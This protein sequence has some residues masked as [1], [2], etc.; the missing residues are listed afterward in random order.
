MKFVRILG[1]VL[2]L[3]LMAWGQGSV[4]SGQTFNR[5]GQPISGA[6][7]AITTTNPCSPTTLCS[8]GAAGGAYTGAT[9][10]AN[11]ASLATDPTLGTPGPNPLVTDSYGNW[12]AYASPGLY[13]S[14][15]YS[16]SITPYVVAVA[17]PFVVSA[18]SFVD[19]IS[20]QSAGGNKTWTG[21][22]IFS[23]TTT[24]NAAASFTS[25][26]SFTGSNTYTT[27]SNTWTV[28]GGNPFLIQ[29]TVGDT[30]INF[31]ST[32]ANSSHAFLG[33]V[34]S[35]GQNGRFD[36]H[37]DTV[38][39]TGWFWCT[40]FGGTNCPMILAGSGNLLT[41]TNNG[42]MGLLINSNNG[43]SST[44]LEIV[45][46][47]SGGKSGQIDLHMSNATPNTA[48]T[49]D[50]INDSAGTTPVAFN[51][52]AANGSLKVNSDS[53]T[54][55]GGVNFASLPVA[56]GN[57]SMIYCTNCGNVF[58]DGAVA[59]VKCVGAGSGAMARR[60]NG[61]WDCN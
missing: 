57:G 15:T 52:N 16:G 25:T 60:Q 31:N 8:N 56:A 10:P 44:I 17:I 37:I 20:N 51:W 48:A 4:F 3:S 40:T 7:V 38:T 61:H 9:P 26:T 30:G 13:W 6:L 49:L 43:G 45:T 36:F 33:T 22:T 53:T 32:G 39:P 46:A 1:T 19:L 42:D 47:V 34:T 55:L 54:Q 2:A 59:G 23:G 58:D 28:G 24:H 50:M 12:S 11:L 27:G 21:N 35:G 29:N 14:T 41:L 18:G 5:S